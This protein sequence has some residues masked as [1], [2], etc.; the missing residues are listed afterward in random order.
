MSDALAWVILIAVSALVVVS[1]LDP[2]DDYA[3]ARFMFALVLFFGLSAAVLWA[4][5][6]IFP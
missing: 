1:L 5:M 2:E 3:R 6:R 4:V